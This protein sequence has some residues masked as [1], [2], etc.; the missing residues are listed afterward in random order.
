MKRE[1]T[2]MGPCSEVQEEAMYIRPTHIS[3]AS[4]T[5]MLGSRRCNTHLTGLSS[6]VKVTPSPLKTPRFFCVP[7]ETS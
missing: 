2:S 1:R 5:I 4:G 7:V 6:S 3:L